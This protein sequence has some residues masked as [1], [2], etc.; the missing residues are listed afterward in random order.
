MK[1]SLYTILLLAALILLNTATAA[2]ADRLPPCPDS[3]NCVSSQADDEWHFIEPLS[4]SGDSQVAWDIL[5]SI[6]QSW[7]RTMILEEEDYYLHVGVRSLVFRFVDD[8][9]FLLNP[10]TKRIHVR[11]A[12][13]M[14][15]SD[16]GV[17]RRRVEQ[18]RKVFLEQQ[19]N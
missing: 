12:S 10:E 18:L 1:K 13:R 3:P 15:Y 19:E 11:S 8:V 6:V 4:Y 9:E 16:F 2:P 17:N 7:K 14:G 5:V